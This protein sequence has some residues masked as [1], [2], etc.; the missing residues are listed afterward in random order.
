MHVALIRHPLQRLHPARGVLNQIVQCLHVGVGMFVDA[1][2]ELGVRDAP[3]EEV[4][5]Q[6]SDGGSAE[7][8]VG[9]VQSAAR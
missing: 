1:V 6:L 8:I 9:G 5:R 4:L 7:V 2:N 3:R